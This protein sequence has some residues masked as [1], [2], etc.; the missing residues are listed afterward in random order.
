MLQV[1]IRLNGVVQL[2][3]PQ[4]GSRNPAFDPLN[5]GFVDAFKGSNGSIA[6]VVN[7]I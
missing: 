6:P 3:L 1:G 7:F 4:Q 5:V 2:F